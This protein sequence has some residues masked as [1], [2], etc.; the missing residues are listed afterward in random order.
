MPMSILNVLGMG[1]VVGLLS[2]LFGVGGG[3]LLTPLLMMAGVPPAVATASDTTQIVAASASG[4]L[5]HSRS[6]NVD[7]GHICRFQRRGPRSCR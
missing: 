3:F 2:G 6:G 1:G 4:T 5:A 7:F